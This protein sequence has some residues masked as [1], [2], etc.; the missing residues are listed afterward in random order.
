MSCSK[1]DRAAQR[2]RSTRE[3]VPLGGAARPALRIGHVKDRRRTSAR[4]SCC[5]TLAKPSHVRWWIALGFCAVRRM[6]I[7]R[8]ATGTGNQLCEAARLL[9]KGPVGLGVCLLVAFAACGPTNYI[10]LKPE[11]A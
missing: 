7:D 11:H 3:P 1:D 2:I 10:P 8:R 5:R 6:R 9:R 4:Q